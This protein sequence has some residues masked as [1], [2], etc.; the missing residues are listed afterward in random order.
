M[1]VKPTSRIHPL[2]VLG[3]IA[4]MVLAACATP[5][6]QNQVTTQGAN[7]DFR[8]GKLLDDIEHTFVEANGSPGC[9]FWRNASNRL[10]HSSGI[11]ILHPNQPGALRMNLILEK[12]PGTYPKLHPQDGT[13]LL[14]VEGTPSFAGGIY[15]FRANNMNCEIE[16][17]SGIGKCEPGTTR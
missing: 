15:R 14:V 6:S 9:G 3:S 1:K 17:A 2:S 10:L 4:L 13:P 7:P 5:A 8:P 11:P 12:Q 16:K